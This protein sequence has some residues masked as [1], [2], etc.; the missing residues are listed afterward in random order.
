MAMRALPSIQH[1]RVREPLALPFVLYVAAFHLLWMAWPFMLYPRLQAFGDATLTYAVLNLSMRLLFW[2]AP[3]LM[4]LRYVDGVNPFEYLKV[5]RHVRRGI[6][7][8]VVLTA[9]N[10]AG[11]FARFGLPHLSMHRVTWNSMLGTSFLIG[12]I[13]EI[14]YRAFM[15]QTFNER[16]G[17]WSAN[18]ITSVL[19]LSIHLP[20]WIALHSW[21]LPAA[22][23]VFVFGF[24]LGVAVKYADS[25]WAAILTH[26][27]NDCLTFVIFGL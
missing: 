22:F 7:V 17:F 11:T 16:F 2:I 19:F 26:S 5:T 3:V 20:G 23:S 27:A 14:P 10:V 12:F 13:E 18:L 4:Y 25:L 1:A 8:A 21:N 24:I 6:I 15:L 9:I